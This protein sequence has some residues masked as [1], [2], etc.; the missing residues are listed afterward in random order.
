MSNSYGNPPITKSRNSDL[1]LC[2]DPAELN[3][4]GHLNHTD[5]V[6]NL[7]T[8]ATT[9]NNEERV[10]IGRDPWGRIALID[11]SEGN[12]VGS[13]YDGGY[14]TSVYS[15]VDRGEKY[16]FTYWF[17]V[18]NKGS[19]GTLYFGLYGYNASTQNVGVYNSGG[20]S[21]TTNPYFSYPGHNLSQFEEGR[22]YMFVAYVH[23]EGTT[24]ASDDTAGFYDMVTGGKVTGVSTG[25]VQYNAVWV[26]AT[27]KTRARQY[28][29][30]STDP[31]VGM[32]WLIPRI[33]KI[34]GS[35]PS[36]TEMLNSP[37]DRL[38]NLAVGD[39]RM[40][41]PRGGSTS[42][43]HTYKSISLNGS[44]DYLDIGTDKDFKTSGGW[45]VSTWFK[46][47]TSHHSK[48]GNF[49]GA[50]SLSYNSWYWTVYQS[51]LAL[52]DLSP[53]SVWK[54]G[55][56]TIATDT[57]YHATLVSDSNNTH[58]YCYLNGEDDM[59]SGWSA[60]NGSWQSGN[61]GLKI[62]YIGR[63]SSAHGRYID[64]NVASTHAWSRALTAAE[65]K[66]NFNQQRARF[67][68]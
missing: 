61:A 22:W 47:D 52:W 25:N 3:S 65:I 66:Q 53:G 32:S 17:R 49:I 9:S 11:R 15:G 60:Y 5:M 30:Y 6:T 48:L 54:Y 35:E 67:G 19:N 21:S 40:F 7:H 44:S 24:S 62:R 42:M 55:D 59:S 45:T 38:S 51:K 36:V 2:I 63:G 20:V 14:T 58:Y 10:E 56:T 28:L 46:H 18:D 12:D 37:Q 50:E 31:D 23:P 4:N 39:G 26:N 8:T 1:I 27:T 68:V 64:G 57:W 41:Y 29:Y 34:D 16:R 43:E 33:D 13:N